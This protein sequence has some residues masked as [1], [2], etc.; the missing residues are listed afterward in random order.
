[1]STFSV[2]APRLDRLFAHFRRLQ[3]A[4]AT[5]SGLFWPKLG[6]QATQ[7]G[8]APRKSEQPTIAHCVML[9][10]YAGAAMI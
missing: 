4:E 3:A 7:Q 2:I 9:V 1:M 10:T 8:I 6:V 5:I